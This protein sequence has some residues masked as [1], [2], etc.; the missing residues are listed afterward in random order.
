MGLGMEDRLAAV[1]VE[2]V[3]VGFEVSGAQGSGF[4]TVIKRLSECAVQRRGH[5]QQPTLR[6][7]V[8]GRHR[9][10]DRQARRAG[11][12]EPSVRGGV[13]AAIRLAGS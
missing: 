10:G 8:D 13:R 3:P 1:G 4:R 7:A 2:F 6:S 9:H 11:G 12:A 5:A